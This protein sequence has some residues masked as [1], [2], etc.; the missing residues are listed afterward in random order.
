MRRIMRWKKYQPS[1]HCCS[2][3]FIIVCV[4][5]MNACTKK[6]NFTF[7]RS[8]SNIYILYRYRTAV[9]NIILTSSHHFVLAAEESIARSCISL[10]QEFLQLC[11]WIMIWY[12]LQQIKCVFWAP[13]E[14]LLWPWREER[15]PE[16][17]KIPFCACLWPSLAY[18][19]ANAANAAKLICSG[20][21]DISITCGTRY[22]FVVHFF[23]SPSC[24]WMTS[25]GEWYCYDLYLAE[26]SALHI[27]LKIKKWE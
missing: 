9:M 17:L 2:R 6:S 11:W 13:W 7:C 8:A 3:K 25:A 10:Y 12:P 5:L 27:K 23:P 18:T 4:K 20:L 21:S 24:P 1:R 16:D 26:I 19:S 14:S 22:C 15:A